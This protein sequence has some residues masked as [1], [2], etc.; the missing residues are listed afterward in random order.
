MTSIRH[1]AFGLRHSAFTLIELLVVI[2]IIAI[3][4]ALLLP[5]LKRAKGQAQKIGCMNNLRQIHLGLMMYANENDGWGIPNIHWPSARVINYA[6]PDTAGAAAWMKSY[7]P[8]SE[9]FRCPGMDKDAI[10]WAI[11]AGAP[12]YQQR[13]PYRILFGTSTHADGADLYGWHMYANSTETS[14]DKA[15]CPNLKFLGG[16]VQGDAASQ[17]ILPA[18]RQ[19]AAMDAYLGME[20]LDIWYSEGWGFG[21]FKNNHFGFDGENIVFM[22]GHAEWRTKSQLSWRFQMFYGYAWW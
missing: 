1:S 4:A 9:I 19:P 13:T 17:Y 20:G 11:R 7:F 21:Y 18:E 2:A 5:A 8:K 22:D 10:P 16:G 3:L 6:P 14:A 15:P 12:P